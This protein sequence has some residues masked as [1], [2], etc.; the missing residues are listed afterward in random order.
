MSLPN[1]IVVEGVIGVG[2]TTLVQALAERLGART[3][4]EVFEENP[5]LPRFY[6]NPGRYAFATEM[7][8]LLSRFDQQE[9]F[10]QEDL[11]QQHAVS[12][13][14][15]EKCRIFGQLTLRG[16]ER[17][18]F[19][20]AYQV[21]AIQVPT[22]DLIVHLHAPIDVLVDR[23]K[24]RGRS[25]EE[26]IDVEYLSSLDRAYREHFEE[27]PES[28]LVQID[29]T[30]TDFRDPRAVDELVKLLERGERGTIK[31]DSFDGPGVRS[32]DD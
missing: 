25:Y 22:P 27:M 32:L 3:V 26:G 4:L 16:A 21:L 12:D 7:F 13:Y 17:D 14:L 28:R 30:N 24:H 8:F 18:A 31:V 20:K 15:F 29:T 9:V 11:L 6:A 23:I 5:F 1:Y 19:E 10:A 2:K